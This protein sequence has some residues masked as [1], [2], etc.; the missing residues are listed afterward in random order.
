M[1]E[2]V[3]CTVFVEPDLPMTP[4]IDQAIHVVVHGALR[5]SSSS[6]SA[7][8]F[9]EVTSKMVICITLAASA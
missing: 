3:Y 2:W 4:V 9:S 7:F 6:T 1:N 5:H 8:N